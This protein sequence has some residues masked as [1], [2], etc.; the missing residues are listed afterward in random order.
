MRWLWPDRIEDLPS[1]TKIWFSTTNINNIIEDQNTY[2]NDL[3]Y[4]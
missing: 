2:N 4:S 1:K 3:E